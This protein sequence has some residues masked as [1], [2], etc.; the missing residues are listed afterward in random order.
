MSPP[1]ATYMRPGAGLYIYIHIYIL[2][3][4]VYTGTLQR[5]HWPLTAMF[6][7]GPLQQYEVL[8]LCRW[9]THNTHTHTHTQHTHTQHTHTQHTHTQH[10]T[11]TH[12]SPV[13]ARD[14]LSSGEEPQ[15][16]FCLP[17][18]RRRS[19]LSGHITG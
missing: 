11:H 2:S 16:C 19:S 4:Y 6:P 10:P 13:R 7:S 5:L 8:H 3:R 18:T 17:L 1:A 9:Y 12:T 15:E 14:P